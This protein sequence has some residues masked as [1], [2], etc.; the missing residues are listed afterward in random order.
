[1]LFSNQYNQILRPSKAIYK[2]KNSKFV[3]YAFIV[4]DI[5]EIDKLLNQVKQNENGANHYCYAYVLNPDK[6]SVYT[7]DDGEPS[8]T[9]GKPILGQIR[10]RELTNTLVIVVRYFGGVKLGISGLI[11]AYKESASIALENASI[12]IKDILEKYK[13][14]FDFEETN[15]VMRILKKYNIKIKDNKF[16]NLCEVYYIVK[17]TNA[18]LVKSELLQNHKIKVELLKL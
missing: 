7:N 11:K 10:S 15:Y 9:A 6:S 8:N 17:K 2:V 13:V 1:M 3:A 16:K 14:I 12:V 18:D 4:V 5:L